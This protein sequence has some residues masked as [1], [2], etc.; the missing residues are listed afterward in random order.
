[1]AS[2]KV[3]IGLL[4]IGDI[5]EITSKS[6]AANIV[7]YLYLDVD[8]LSP[9]EHPSYALDQKRLQYNAG[10]ILKAMNPER[11][12]DYDKLIGVV[13][14]DIFVPIL[15]HVFGEAQQGGRCAL[16]S[17]F[18]LKRHV[19]GSDAPL[20]LLLLRAAKVAIHEL[21]HLFNLHHCMDGAC[22]MHF[23]G[24]LEDMDKVPL[25]FCNYC[26]IYFKDALKQWTA[27][28]P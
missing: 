1:M 23:S 5:P 26:S 4:P 22:L 7:G 18:R 13:D 24:G 3:L 9:A 2:K 27:G 14:L 25:Y 16:V 20:P 21:G 12:Q 17:T 28:N 8:I 19:D 11:L 15:T 6:I 10:T